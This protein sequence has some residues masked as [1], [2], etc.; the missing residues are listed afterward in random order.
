MRAYQFTGMF[1]MT[2]SE[3]WLFNVPLQ[4]QCEGRGRIVEIDGALVRK[5]KYNRGSQVEG[6]WLFGI[7]DKPLNKRHC[8]RIRDRSTAALLALAEKY[9]LLG[10]IKY[11]ND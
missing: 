9:I 1:R 5:G 3:K 4:I 7:W 8:E 11:S 2:V 6:D 10:T